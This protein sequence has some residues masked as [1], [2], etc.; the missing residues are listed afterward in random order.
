M[1]A[2][3]TRI[4]PR[5][6]H[7]SRRTL[8]TH[9]TPPSGSGV[10]AVKGQWVQSSDWWKEVGDELDE[11][12]PAEAYRLAAP[13]ERCEPEPLHL[14]AAA[15]R[16]YRA[17]LDKFPNDPSLSSCWKNV[18]KCA[19]AINWHR[20]PRGVIY[21]PSSRSLSASHWNHQTIISNEHF[22]HSHASFPASTCKNAEMALGIPAAARRFVCSRSG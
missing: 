4:S 22:L 7:R 6:S 17:I 10:E 13:L 14:V 12:L 11:P 16:A 1:I 15:V 5:P 19:L 9:G 20:R 3:G 21:G 8:L 18:R 2:V